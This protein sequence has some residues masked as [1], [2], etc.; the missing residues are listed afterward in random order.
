M[1]E[2]TNVAAQEIDVV[3]L[4]DELDIQAVVNCH[5]PMVED[6]D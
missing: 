3:E 4:L 6:E 5:H 2:L 1:S